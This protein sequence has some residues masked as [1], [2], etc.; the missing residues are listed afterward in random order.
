MKRVKRVYIAGPMTGIE[1]FNFPA[2]HAAARK[3]R[4]DGYDVVSPAE[5]CPEKGK[6]WE[7]YMRKDLAAMLTCDTIYLLQGWES[8]RGAKLERS[9]AVELK[10]EVA[11]QPQKT[12]KR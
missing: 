6:S 8:S 12:S 5:L 9:V 2:F 3:L 11:Y 1:E 10:M 4:A 7:W